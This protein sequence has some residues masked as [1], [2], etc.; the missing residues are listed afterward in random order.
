MSK[1]DKNEGLLLVVVFVGLILL[2]FLY[3]VLKSQEDSWIKDENGNWIQHGHPST[4]TYTV[5]MDTCKQYNMSG[6]MI[7]KDVC[8]CVKPDLECAPNKLGT[9]ALECKEVT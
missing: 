3:A 4:M 9:V 6:F 5:C 1:K 2:C 8:Q 7:V